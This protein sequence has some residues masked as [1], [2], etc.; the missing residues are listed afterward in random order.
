ML[1]FLFL[2]LSCSV[3]EDTILESQEVSGTHSFVY[4]STSSV[5]DPGNNANAYDTAGQ[6]HDALFEAYFSSI[7][8]KQQSVVDVVQS[9]TSLAHSNAHFVHLSDTS[10]VFDS[11]L[12]LEAVLKSP[13]VALTASIDLQ[14]EDPTIALLFKDFLTQFEVHCSSEDDYAV[15][16]AEVVAF[17]AHILSMPSLTTSDVAQILTTTSV[18]RYSVA[19]RKKR[20]KKNTDPEWD[21]LIANMTGSLEGSSK[22]MQE[23]IVFS[24]VVGILENQ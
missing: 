5:F 24:L 8:Q 9:I 18:L 2:S 22:N 12:R 20:P 13:N 16:H 3:S 14:I 17:E 4:Q 15:L 10:Y 19:R 11:F 7:D 6:L 1:S 23:A 21:L